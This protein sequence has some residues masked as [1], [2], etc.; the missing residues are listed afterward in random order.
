ML[1][2]LK[3]L[4]LNK[5]LVVF[6]INPINTSIY[7][8]MYWVFFFNTELYTENHILTKLF[9]ENLHRKN[10]IECILKHRDGSD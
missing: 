5:I 4:F 10:P 1:V 7:L 9:K 2:Y 6:F 8:Y 3:L